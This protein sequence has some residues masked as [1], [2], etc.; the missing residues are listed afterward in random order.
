MSARLARRCDLLPDESVPSWVSRLAACNHIDSA[1]EFCLDM[2]FRYQDC[3][4]G[5]PST[6]A[7][8]S[9][10]TGTPLAT[11]AQ[12]SLQIRKP[13]Y[14]FRGER[15]ST[16]TLR[17]RW[18]YICP[19]CIRND[20]ATQSMD[21]NYLP[22]GRLS[23]Q[24][25]FMRTCPLHK[26]P[27]VEIA[28]L[29]D[30]YSGGFLYH[31]KLHRQIIDCL[32]Q[33]ATVR[34]PSIVQEY[35][36]SRLFGPAPQSH[37]LN[38]LSL[39]A[40]I[41]T[42]ESLGALLT[43]GPSADL[44]RMSE[45]EL[46]HAGSVGFEVARGGEAGI[47]KVL[48]EAQASHRTMHT[49]REKI[50]SLYGPFYHAFARKI[51]SI[52]CAPIRDLLR[53]HIIDTMPVG[54]GDIILHQTVEKRVI[55]SVWTAAQE[56]GRHPQRLRNILAAAGMIASDHR[57][58]PSHKVL[59]DAEKARDLI[60]DRA[61]DLGI[62]GIATYLDSDRRQA[63]LLV[64][65]GQI[66]PRIDHFAKGNTHRKIYSK[67]DLDDLFEAIYRRACII[68]TYESPICNVLQAASN[69]GVPAVDII[70][71]I[72]QGKLSWVGRKPGSTGYPSVLVDATEIKK[73][74]WGSET[75]GVTTGDAIAFL[76]AGR[77]VVAALV[78]EGYL[79]ESAIYRPKYNRALR[80][81][82]RQSLENFA[83]TYVSFTELCRTIK[84]R[85]VDI[86]ENLKDVSPAIERT[87]VGATYYLRSQIPDM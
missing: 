80:L 1:H 27:I 46:D 6:L 30:R 87:R 68:E 81:I 51:K 13:N 77:K 26:C 25:S 82:D 63:S 21:R 12:A 9:E 18:L 50:G 35:A 83:S 78:R 62:S 86:I 76:A 64:R 70:A 69:S 79:L 55:H 11:I 3:V 53:R 19:A 58:Y 72:Q 31:L 44:S 24:F 10:L 43:I 42:C 71:L 45:P 15:F 54:P 47:R 39:Y 48:S 32:A 60:G 37:W 34:E 65:S 52:D 67:R 49:R 33:N 16:H 17:H 4:A 75:E 59:F 85:Y 56:T 66:R 84:L 14:L 29:P 5:K 73:I 22:Y 36:I 40:A 61:D 28:K 38:S 8:L 74:I 57:H 41:I 20:F 7:K 23:W 2:G